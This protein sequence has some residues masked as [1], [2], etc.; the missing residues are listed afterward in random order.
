M[1]NFVSFLLQIGAH[2]QLPDVADALDVLSAVLSRSRGS[3][4]A[5]G[6]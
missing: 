6:L 2:Q 1:L 3:H 4:A 5:V